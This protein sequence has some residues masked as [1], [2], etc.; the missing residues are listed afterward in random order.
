[1]RSVYIHIPFCK[2]ICSYC[3]FCKMLYNAS[4]AKTYLDSLK[5]EINEYYEGDE[6][7]TIYIGG[8]TPSSLS[9]I[10][11]K[12]LFGILKIF[13]KSENCEFT[14]EMNVNDINDEM[15]NVLKEN[16]VNRVSVGV[17][18]FNKDNLKFLNRKHTKK[19]IFKNISILKKYFE[20]IN[21]DLIYALPIETQSVFKSDVKSI[22]KLN[23]PHI[24]TYSLI[25]EDNTVLK[26]KNIK[27]IDEE[28]DFKMYTY[29][30]KKFKSAGY[31]HYEVSNFARTGYESRHNTNYW[32]NAEYY[33]FGLGA[34]GYINGIRYEN[35][36]SLNKYINNYY[37]FSEYLVSKKEDME[38]EIM[39]GLRKLDGLDLYEFFNKFDTNL[40]DEFNI[41][42][43]LKNK[44][45]IIEDKKLKIPEDKIYIMNEII[46][47][48]LK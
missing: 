11:L 4:W 31:N 18:S 22:L 5:R 9:I 12:E 21:V 32:C 25:I 20:N 19:E 7:D 48:I 24:S 16:G 43:L 14:F 27:N 45:L 44:F 47:N 13:K 1:M 15:C 33:G 23:V 10:E 17:E 29:I 38:N 3:D 37:R 35:T 6:V 40:Q 41:I 26:I 46:N 42:D 34:H 2:S 28:E 8:G 36:R 30:C 39:L